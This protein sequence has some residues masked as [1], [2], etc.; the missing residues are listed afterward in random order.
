MIRLAPARHS[1]HGADHGLPEAAVRRRPARPLLTALVAAL[2]VAVAVLVGGCAKGPAT[3]GLASCPTLRPG[4]SGDCVRGVQNALYARGLA[5]GVDGVFGPSTTAALRQFQTAQ[6]LTT[7]GI[8][9]PE[10]LAKLN[11][12]LCAR[13]AGTCTYYF[14]RQA[15]SKIHHALG[16]Q[17]GTG[18]QV[19]AWAV[20]R[21]LRT[22][23]AV[24]ACDLLGP[25]GAGVVRDVSG[26]AVNADA[27]LVLDVRRVP[28]RVYADGGSACI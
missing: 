2:L 9:G 23:L 5:L 21:T 28:I 10:T 6:G 24:V 26:E 11:E 8:A 19:A 25:L 17:G 27:C 1:D 3:G 18:E 16:Q 20:C 22:P 12:S 14:D 15:T 13:L 7:D 4:D